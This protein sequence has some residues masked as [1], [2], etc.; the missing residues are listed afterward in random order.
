LQFK[1]EFA[2]REAEQERAAFASDPD[3]TLDWS[4]HASYERDG[5][6]LDHFPHPGKFE[7]NIYRPSAREFCDALPDWEP[8]ISDGQ[9]VLKKELAMNCWA[10]CYTSIKPGQIAGG[11]GDDSIRVV[12]Q[13]TVGHATYYHKNSQ[14]WV[15]RRV[16]SDLN[17]AELAAAH[18]AA[19]V[20]AQVAAFSRECPDCSALQVKL[21]SRSAKNNGRKYWKC[22][23]TGEWKG[24][25]D[26]D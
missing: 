12:R 10:F 5:D 8:T 11:T 7:D 21:V 26:E 2:R 23:N 4:K 13:D 6:V 16:P 18:L 25:D 1:A 15:T 3:Q 24:W 22:W 14:D 19:K 20:E 17:T 9:L